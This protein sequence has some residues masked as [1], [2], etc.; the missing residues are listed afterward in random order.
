MGS[1]SH[2]STCRG[3]EIGKKPLPPYVLITPARNEAAFIELTLQSVTSQ[4]IVP[5]KW[6]I[7]SDGSTD[8]TD[9]IVKKFTAQ[10]KWIELVRMPERKERH[11]AGKVH[12]FNAGYERVKGLDYDIIGSLDADISFQTDYFAFL[13]SKFLENPLLGV[14]GTPFREGTSQYN[15]RFSRKE[16]VSGACQ[17]F[18]RECFEAIG[19]YVPI[20]EGAID[21][22]AVVTARMKGWITQTFTDKVCIHHRQMGSAKHNFVLATF[23]SGY[24][25]YRMG[26]HPLW[27]LLRSCYQMTRKPIFF[28]G[29]ILLAGYLWAMLKRTEKPVSKEFVRFR[30]QEQIRWLREY[31]GKV[32]HCLY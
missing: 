14:G 7:V 24:G 28:G 31:S 22:T 15:Y 11:F 2:D 26:V 10:F 21:L 1:V 13:L 4:T 19:G 32:F 5:L 25:D 6:V 18:R 20:K 9:E 3:I 16:H 8:G 29:A 30:R 12:A 23:K 17:L 27:Q